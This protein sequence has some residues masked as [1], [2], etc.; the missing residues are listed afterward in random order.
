MDTLR[1]AMKVI[2]SAEHWVS[3]KV[4]LSA[5]LMVVWWAVRSAKTLVAMSVV[6]RVDQWG[7]C[8]AVK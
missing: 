4:G 1:A 8:W 6:S 5:L 7:T 2:P 3:K